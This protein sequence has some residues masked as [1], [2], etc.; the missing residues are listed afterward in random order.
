MAVLFCLV[1][2]VVLLLLLGN[3][4]VFEHFLIYT[5]PKSGNPSF[6]EQLL[7]KEIM[8]IELFDLKKFKKL[9]LLVIQEQGCYE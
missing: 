4:I 2:F 8:Y 1:V 3:I 6:L 9:K 5:T 7:N